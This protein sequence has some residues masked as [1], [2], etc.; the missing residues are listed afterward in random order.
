MSGNWDPRDPRWMVPGITFHP[1]Y[2]VGMY[3]QLPPP[4]PPPPPSP[5]YQQNVYAQY[6]A[7]PPQQYQYPAQYQPTQYPPAQSYAVQQA[8]Y[9]E[10]AQYQ[11]PANYQAPQYSS[12]YAQPAISQS[13]QLVYPQQQV[14]QPVAGLSHHCSVI[15]EI[16][17]APRYCERNLSDLEQEKISPLDRKIAASYLQTARRNAGFIDQHGRIA[18]SEDSCSSCTD[19]VR[20]FDSDFV[21]T[22]HLHNVHLHGPVNFNDRVNVNVSKPGHIVHNPHPAQNHTRALESSGLPSPVSPSIIMPEPPPPS[23]YLPTNTY[24]STNIYPPTNYPPTN[25]YPPPQSGHHNYPVGYPLYDH[26]QGRWILPGGGYQHPTP[27]Q[28]TVHEL[29]GHPVTIPPTQAPNIPQPPQPVSPRVDPLPEKAEPKTPVK[30]T[31]I[32]ANSPWKSPKTVSWAEGT[33]AAS[34]S[35]NT[36]P[37]LKPTQDSNIKEKS[38]D[39]GVAFNDGTPAPKQDVFWG[40]SD[41]KKNTKAEVE[42]QKSVETTPCPQQKKSQG[43]GWGKKTSSG[44]GSWKKKP[45]KSSDTENGGAWGSLSSEKDQ[46]GNSQS[47]PSFFS[48]SESKDDEQF[49]WGIDEHSPD[50]NLGQA[51]DNENTEDPLSKIEIP[52]VSEVIQA[53]STDWAWDATPGQAKENPF[54]FGAKV[55]SKD[56]DII[57]APKKWNSN[58]NSKGSSKQSGSSSKSSASA[59]NKS[60]SSGS[61]DAP[62]K[63]PALSAFSRTKMAWGGTPNDSQSPASGSEKKDKDARSNP[64]KNISPSGN[65]GVQKEENNVWNIS[66]VSENGSSHGSQTKDKGKERATENN[67]GVVTEKNDS[68]NEKQKDKGKFSWGTTAKGTKLSGK[69]GETGNTESSCGIPTEMKNSPGGSD[70]KDKGKGKA[71]DS[72]WN[73]PAGSITK[74]KETLKA[75]WGNNKKT[76]KTDDW[77]INDAEVDKLLSEPLVIKPNGTNGP[78]LD[79]KVDGKKELNSTGNTASQDTKP[80]NTKPA[81][82]V[83]KFEVKDVKDTG[84]DNKQTTNMAGNKTYTGQLFCAPLPTPENETGGVKSNVVP[85]PPPSSPAI[86]PKSASQDNLTVVPVTIHQQVL[87]SSSGTASSSFASLN[88]PNSA[89][90][91]ESH[92]WGKTDDSD[93]ENND[94]EWNPDDPYDSYDNDD[95]SGSGSGDDDTSWVGFENDDEQPA[96]DESDQNDQDITEWAPIPELPRVASKLGTKD[97]GVAEWATNV[98]PPLKTTKKW[99]AKRK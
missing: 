36:S 38:N 91:D 70:T 7:A 14:S 88:T 17:V 78:S 31:N 48:S 98:E 42:Q 25:T 28:P 12:S 79:E 32:P 72:S 4:P 16:H 35:T 60:S 74:K 27:G 77:G 33:K 61:N 29:P 37:S 18:S 23:Q 76:K 75:K 53:K 64:P 90:V 54:D 58:W 94:N 56:A 39:W 9:Q 8:P 41:E 19:D 51:C 84:K 15:K 63:G 44:P 92:P 69:L 34:P 3:P 49:N 30:N 59:D 96:E 80:V 83:E 85:P 50:K 22:G 47:S 62:W 52:K 55:K 46:S 6:Q 11:Y 20:G 13:H 95:R 26:V 43:T 10:P 21:S 81:W 86:P 89:T 65:W 2:G 73:S 87:S 93:N 82:S 71:V 24:P 97:K 45:K 40:G 57:P 67:W 66:P 5:Q 1:T 99:T 68:G